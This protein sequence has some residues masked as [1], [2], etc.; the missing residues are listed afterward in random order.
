MWDVYEMYPKHTEYTGMCILPYLVICISVNVLCKDIL[1]G[2]DS[3][4]VQI[5]APIK[6]AMYDQ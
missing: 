6:R 1:L 3:K 2:N 4:M 5:G